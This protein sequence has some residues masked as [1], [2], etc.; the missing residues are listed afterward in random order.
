MHTFY[1]QHPHS[2]KWFDVWDVK[3]L[4]SFLESWAPASSLTNFQLI[5]K[6]D[7][8]LTLVTAKHNS[9]LT[10]LH[11]DYQG[12]FLQDHAA[13][14]VPASGGKMDQLG[15]LPSQIHTKS[16]SSDNFCPVFYLKVYL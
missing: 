15:N 2:F 4:L 9:D 16:H 10:L 13:I 6:T 12:L 5:L 11:V 1:L 3:W 8:L 14:F 7:T